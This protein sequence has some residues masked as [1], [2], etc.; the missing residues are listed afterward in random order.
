MGIYE[1]ILED[2]KAAILSLM[3]GYCSLVSQFLHSHS[4]RHC[5]VTYNRYE[6]CD[7]W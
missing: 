1:S 7:R 4:P 5:L 6:A 2:V 3:R